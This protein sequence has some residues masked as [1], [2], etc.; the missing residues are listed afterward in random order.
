MLLLKWVSRLALILGA[1]LGSVIG[2][3][4][5]VYG[6]P[7]SD[8]VTFTLCD[9][10][11]WRGL[12][13]GKTTFYEAKSILSGMPDLVWKGQTREADKISDKFVMFQNNIEVYIISE[14]KS[15][16]E[17]LL[18]SISFNETYFSIKLGDLIR[19]FG[20]PNRISAGRNRQGYDS[21]VGVDFKEW[22]VGTTTY[23]PT[24]TLNNICV[25]GF[26]NLPIGRFHFGVPNPAN[27]QNTSQQRYMEM[28]HEV[29]SSIR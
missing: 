29:C 19:W 17:K 28:V 27:H 12:I 10:P 22:N 7:R 6:I 3:S 26:E 13:P 20:L 15:F 14:E 2:I 18:S 24:V 1:L 23:P 5:E 25:T 21:Y 4:R 8:G 11:C 16:K 9:P